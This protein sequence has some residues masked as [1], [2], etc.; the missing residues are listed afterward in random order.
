M[1]FCH[2]TCKTNDETA[3]PFVGKTYMSRLMLVFGYGPPDINGIFT[4]RLLLQTSR[5]GGNGTG[6]TFVH[7]ENEG[8]ARA[9]SLSSKRKNDLH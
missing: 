4:N 6:G 5:C 9:A 1:V 3:T 7:H 8:S 2:S